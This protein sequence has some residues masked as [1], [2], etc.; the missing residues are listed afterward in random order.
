MAARGGDVEVT[1]HVQKETGSQ[2][3]LNHLVSSLTDKSFR[4]ET[5][6]LDKLG[7]TLNRLIF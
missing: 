2:L 1:K 4:G 7:E 3:P 6:I 5:D